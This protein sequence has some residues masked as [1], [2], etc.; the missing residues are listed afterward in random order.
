MLS[1]KTLVGKVDNM[2]I[3]HKKLLGKMWAES[4]EKPNGKI[5]SA[6]GISGKTP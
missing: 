3:S 2:T 5:Q 4:L 6:I 1:L